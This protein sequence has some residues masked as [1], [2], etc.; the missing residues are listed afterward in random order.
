MRIAIIGAGMAGIACARG[1]AA[2]GIAPVVYDKGRGIGGRLATRRAGE[3]LQF[4]HGAQYVT[5]RD[6]RFAEVLAGL[7]R[8]GAVA[9]WHVGGGRPRFVGLP[10]M[11]RLV[12]ALGDGIEVRSGVAVAAVDRDAH[13]KIRVAL[14]D[15][16]VDMFDRAVIT[17]PAP[18]A[19]G[20][21][22]ADD[23][24]AERLGR[25]RFDPCLTLMAA[26][27]ADLPRPFE[28]A[29]EDDDALAWIA[30][31]SSK[32]G[33]PSGPLAAWVAQAGTGFSVQHL[34]KGADEIAALMLP[35]LAAR[36]GIDPTLALHAVAHRW[37]YARVSQAL[38]E[39]F[40][41]DDAGRIFAGGDWCLGPRVEAAWQSGDAIA[42]EILARG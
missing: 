42:T 7:E 6:P 9:R 34:E 41:C 36:L 24:L 37:R 38:E 22:G 8:D 12:R 16:R 2:A 35:L 27:P 21:L 5:A 28:A 20:L 39:P 32:P 15:G 33:R 11:S 14:P 40:L 29:A 18:Q 10:G 23:D 31:D 17:V 1:L 30:L 3:G 25:A 13:G 4:D 26:F 19:A